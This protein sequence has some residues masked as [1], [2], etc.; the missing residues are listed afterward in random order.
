MYIDLF[1]S[2]CF[3]HRLSCF[4]NERRVWNMTSKYDMQL[5]ATR[6][7]FPPN[8]ETIRQTMRSQHTRAASSRTHALT[9]S[10]KQ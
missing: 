9:G 6:R 7:L 3:V 8:V 1:S 5:M 4:F 2:R 10:R